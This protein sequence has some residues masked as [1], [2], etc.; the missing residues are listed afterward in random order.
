MSDARILA[1]DDSAL[2]RRWHRQVVEPPQNDFV[3]LVSASSSTPVSGTG[4]TTL[5]TQLAKK[6]DRSP[7]P[8]DASEQ[9][10]LDVGELAYDLA[11]E[12]PPGSALVGDEIQGT[13]GATGFDNR[14][15][16]KQ[17]V[18]DGISAILANR[19]SG[20]TIVLGAQQI[21]SLDSRLIPIIDIWILIRE[22]PPE[23][24][25]TVHTIHDND[26]NLSS[27]E[28]KTPRIE[29]ITWERI[30][31]SNENY[32]T[33]EEMKEQAKTR[34]GSDD[35][36]SG[37]DELPKPAQIELAQALRDA[38]KTL[39]EIEQSDK[40]TYSR[41]WLGEHTTADSD[42]ENPETATA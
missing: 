17:E 26:F 14:R 5:L 37:T 6:F 27:V 9:A 40:I 39:R 15:G 35:D 10:T 18:I 8:F 16:M 23:P 3:I 25:A 20:Y 41:T 28:P 11:P 30:P 32:S 36:D 42:D 24:V 33:L 1:N 12:L 21:G 19:N 22:A 7:G 29:T 2:H 31:A 13:P 34:G 38:G 4:K